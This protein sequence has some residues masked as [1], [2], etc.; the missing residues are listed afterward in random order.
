M[1]VEWLIVPPAGTV[2]QALVDQFPI[3]WFP[4]LA[5]LVTFVAAVFV[6]TSGSAEVNVPVAGSHCRL[7]PVTVHVAT[8]PA[9][10]WQARFI[11]S[12]LLAL[13]PGA[14]I[15]SITLP[16]RTFIPPHDGYWYPSIAR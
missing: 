14:S 11:P 3:T 6:T 5:R 2:I 10:S 13:L 8:Q 15:T 9:D 4:V 1:P 7:F 16:I 12:R